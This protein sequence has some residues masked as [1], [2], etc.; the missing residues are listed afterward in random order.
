MSLHKLPYIIIFLISG[1]ICKAQVLS[2]SIPVDTLL[3]DDGSLY[4]GQ[5]ADSLFNGHGTLI[6]ADGTVYDGDWKDGLWDGQGTLVYPDGDLYKGSFRQHAKEGNGTYI[7]SSG[8]RYDGEWKDDRFNGY[9]KLL[10]EDGGIYEGAWKEDKKHGYGKLITFEGRSHSGYFYNDEF[11]G[12]PFDTTID[13]DSTLTDE[14]KEWGFEHEEEI[15]APKLTLAFSYS[16]KAMATL[17]MW[18]DF[19]G[20]TFWGFSIGAV[21]EPP[22]QGKDSG[23]A[24]SS[25]TNDV[26]FEGEYISSIYTIEAGY[27]FKDLSI[28][29]ALGFGFCKAYRN[30]RTNGSPDSYL[31]SGINYG[32][33]YYISL[34]TGGSLVYRAYMRYPIKIKNRPKLSTYLGYGNSEGFF[35]GLGIRLSTD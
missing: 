10:F 4:M 5:I 8:A 27:T 34:I 31:N 7:Y 29:G 3:L 24:W 2:D 6:Y 13:P 35:L 14:L 23:F 15:E 9:G 11:L 28:G 21:L 33:A 25:H 26:H 19:S 12:M 20:N 18:M 17:T 32:D 22:M 16:T 1:I 30:C